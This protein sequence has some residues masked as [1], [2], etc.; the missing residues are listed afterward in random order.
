V[1]DLQK[2]INIACPHM[3]QGK[4]KT[5]VVGHPVNWQ[6]RANSGKM[7]DSLA[8]CWSLPTKAITLRSVFQ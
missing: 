1:S 7:V 5:S 3:L 2:R 8:N 6:K 4:Q